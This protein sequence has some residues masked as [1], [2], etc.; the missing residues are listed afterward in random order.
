VV[1]VDR[2]NS[3][4]LDYEML[5]ETVRGLLLNEAR[6]LFKQSG[7]RSFKLRQ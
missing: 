1:T 5:E 4:I 6:D 7:P 2:Q 3:L